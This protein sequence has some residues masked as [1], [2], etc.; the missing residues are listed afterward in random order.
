MCFS[1]QAMLEIATAMLAIGGAVAIM[2]AVMVYL[3]CVLFTAR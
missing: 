2:M 3:W 1:D